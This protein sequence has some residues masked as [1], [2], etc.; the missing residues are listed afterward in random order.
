MAK[1]ILVIED[2]KELCEILQDELS[3]QGYKVVVAMNGQEGLDKLQ[4]IQPDM[5]ICDRSMPVMTG[6]QLL[7]RIRGAYPQYKNLP[8]VFLTALTD[9]RDQLSVEHL[10]PTAYLAKPINFDLLSDTIKKILG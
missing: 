8:F 1:T 9:P 5:I 6:Y 10:E 3:S 7:E 2:E 4:E